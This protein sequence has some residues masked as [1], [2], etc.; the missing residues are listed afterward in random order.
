MPLNVYMTD[1]IQSVEG[2]DLLARYL[3]LGEPQ[4]VSRC[5]AQSL[6]QWIEFIGAS[7]PWL[8]LAA[9]SGIF[10]KSYLSKL[11]ELAAEGTVK[12]FEKLKRVNGAEPITE[13]SQI[14][15]KL[16]SQMGPLGSVIIGINLQ[17]DF[18]GA[19]LV[20]DSAEPLEIAFK[21]ASFVSR[22]AALE[23][24][25]RREIADGRAPTGNATVT[26]EA[27]GSLTVEWLDRAMT[28][29]YKRHLP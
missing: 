25:M 16:R 21:L 10:L 19:V 13:I 26:I 7:G 20:I 2:F 15:A 22:V 14:F 17:N 6:P 27:D 11:G 1:E 3:E 28:G 12:A 4:F 8:A 9:A 29:K 5:S 18:Y 24:L 23:E